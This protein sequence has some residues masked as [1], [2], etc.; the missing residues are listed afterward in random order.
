MHTNDFHGYIQENGNRSAGAAR[1]AALFDSLRAAQRQVVVLDAGDCVSG[2]PV[3]YLF[4]GNPIFEVMNAMGYDAAALGNHE[5]DY[6]W[7]QIQGYRRTANFPLLS[8]NARDPGNALVADSAAVVFER[9]GVRVG[10]IGVTTEWTRQITT[11]EGNAG[12]SFDGEVAAVRREVELLRDRCHLLVVLS[13]CGSKAD[14]VLAAAVPGIDLIVGGHDHKVVTPPSLVNGTALVQAGSYGS[15]VGV[16]RVV[17][18]RDSRRVVAVSGE[19]VPA[20]Q[21]STR[22]EEVA[23]LVAHWEEQVSERVD[24]AISRTD[25]KWALEEM[26]DFVEHVLRMQSGADVGYYNQGGIRAAFAP[27]AILIRHIWNT[28]PFGNP[29]AVVT[30][31]GESIAGDVRGRFVDLDVPIDPDRIY[32]IAT[33]RFV[34]EAIRVRQHF[35]RPDR[36][37]IEDDLVREVVI[38]HVRDFGVDSQEYSPFAPW[39]AGAEPAPANSE[40]NA[41]EVSPR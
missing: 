26:Y 8:C 6:G 16:T 15:H 37:R 24:V 9:R 2:T 22:D 19:V 38:D 5:F 17:V 36:V 40:T 32:T 3:S 7:A 35:G 39:L 30:I 13:H 41:I 23:G 11:S 28:L 4:K 27:G 21:M 12:I 29:V 33:N 31:R 25:H 18:D 14:S 10:V 34:T 20:W 1:I